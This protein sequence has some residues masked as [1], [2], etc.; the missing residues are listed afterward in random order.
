MCSWP[1][2]FGYIPLSV[3]DKRYKNEIAREQ[4]AGMT[5]CQCSNCNAEGGVQ[6]INE[7]RTTSR[8]DLSH[9]IET[10]VMKPKTST[11]LTEP[12]L[13]YPPKPIVSNVKQLICKQDD[14]IRLEEEFVE[15]AVA[16]VGNFEILFA[17]SALKNSG[18]LPEVLFNR[19]HAWLI[20]KNYNLISEG[21]CLRKILG[22][23]TIPE[24][25]KMI[26][27]CIHEWL[28]SEHF[29]KLQSRI[30]M[31]QIEEDQHYLDERLLEFEYKTEKESQR[32]QKLEAARAVQRRKEERLEK[33]AEKYERQELAQERRRNK[34]EG[35]SALVRGQI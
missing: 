19:E 4:A 5:K 2:R 31:A 14:P 23:Q 26:H 35:A 7:F 1:I 21:L 16:L 22:S 32:L 8:S 20:V 30:D 15:L 6:L 27:D 34:M 17:S 29:S 28:S 25:F 18:I 10:P 3:E 11:D 9:L 33:A 13:W 12:Y 24:L